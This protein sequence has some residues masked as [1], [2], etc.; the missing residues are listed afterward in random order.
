MTG[1]TETYELRDRVAFAVDGLMRDPRD[2]EPRLLRE[3]CYAIAD[4]VLAEIGERVSKEALT[5]RIAMAEDME[6]SRA[7][8]LARALLFSFDIRPKKKES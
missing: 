5:K 8:R 1:M 7:K 2:N 4:T 6:I 3:E